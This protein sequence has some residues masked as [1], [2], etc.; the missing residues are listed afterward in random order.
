MILRNASLTVSGESDCELQPRV[1]KPSSAA[2]DVAF[3]QARLQDLMA[4]LKVLKR[5]KEAAEANAISAQQRH[6]E[7]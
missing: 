7:R 3:L 4:K 1:S 6:D 2:K 5:E